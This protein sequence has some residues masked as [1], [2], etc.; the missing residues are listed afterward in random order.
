MNTIRL[1][2]RC[3]LSLAKLPVC[4]FSS[5]DETLKSKILNAALN[6]VPQ[7]GWTD[8]S[9]THAMKDLGLPPLAHGIINRGPVEFIELFLEKKRL[10]VHETM[11][12]FCSES[13]DTTSDAII[14]KAI[15]AH[16]EYTLPYLAVWPKALAIL[17]EPENL[18]SSA[19][20]MVKAL[21]DICYFAKIE[22]VGTDWYSERFMLFTLFSTSELHLLTDYSEDFTDTR[23]VTSILKLSR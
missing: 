20:N 5:T 10:H 15:E 6:N 4:R 19:G 3:K 8:E 16:F 17:A 2:L 1:A 13:D 9:I 11:T 23:Y 7:Y 12:Q 18:H 14:L 21:D 22:N